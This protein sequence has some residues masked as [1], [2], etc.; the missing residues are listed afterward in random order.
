M[1]FAIMAHDKPNHL[2]LRMKTRPVHLQWLEKTDTK[3][4]YAGPLLSDDGQTFI[5]SLIVAEFDSLD[6]ARAFQKSD[7]YTQAGL[8]ERVT[9][10]PTRKVFPAA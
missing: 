2:D 9:V 1:L 4:T 5:G 8:F 10:M 7:P 6:A 3:L